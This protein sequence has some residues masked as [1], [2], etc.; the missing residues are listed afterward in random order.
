MVE[1][2]AIRNSEDYRMIAY[3][4]VLG[5]S[6]ACVALVSCTYFKYFKGGI[7]GDLNE[8]LTIVGLQQD[9]GR[10]L[11]K[12][13]VFSVRYYKRGEQPCPLGDDYVNFVITDRVSYIALDKVWMKKDKAKVLDTLKEGDTIVMKARVF[14]VD[15]KK[16]PNLEAL[17]IVPE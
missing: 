11:N 4:R 14:K 5:I 6:I 17:E 9:P 10:Y 7:Y 13:I 16:D 1:D 15:S 12:D 8:D 3:I 2:C